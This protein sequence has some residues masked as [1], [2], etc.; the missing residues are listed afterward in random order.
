M[1]WL[2]VFL[3]WMVGVISF[4]IIP[5]D[6]PRTWGELA[7]AVPMGFLGPTIWL[8]ILAQADFWSQPIFKRR[9]HDV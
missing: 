6:S 7:V 1:T 9:P 5:R 4:L 3:W 8:A 2:W